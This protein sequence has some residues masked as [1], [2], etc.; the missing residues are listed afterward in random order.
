[1]YIYIYTSQCTNI[2]YKYITKYICY[3]L[4][5]RSTIF[6]Y[7]FTITIFPIILPIISSF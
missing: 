1:M 5:H 7:M 6:Y 2:Y 3:R 4:Y